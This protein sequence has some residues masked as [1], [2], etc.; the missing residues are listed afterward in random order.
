MYLQYCLENNIDYEVP[1]DMTYK[2]ALIIYDN[3][4]K[5]GLRLK[6]YWKCERLEH[7][8]NVIIPLIHTKNQ[9]VALAY[10]FIL[11]TP[12]AVVCNYYDGYVSDIDIDYDL[13]A[14]Y[15]AELKLNYP[16]IK[17]LLFCDSS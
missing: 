15:S 1:D 9:H 12:Q 11:E 3:V 10:L 7:F 14:I 5:N 6:Q 4:K 8:T 17:T 13:I 16:S 2:Q